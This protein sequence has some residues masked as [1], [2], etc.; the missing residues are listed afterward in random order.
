[1]VTL[2]AVVRAPVHHDGDIAEGEV[3]AL[4]TSIESARFSRAMRAA[5]LR[6]AVILRVVYY[7]Q[8]IARGDIVEGE[9]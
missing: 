1:M 3:C 8:L 5:F 6:P 9:T 4:S 7:R 2:F